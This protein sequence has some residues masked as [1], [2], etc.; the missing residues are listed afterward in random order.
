MSADG[1]AALLAAARAGDGDAFGRLAEPQRHGIRLHCYRFLGSLEDAEDLTQETLL[2]AWRRLDGFEGRSSF[3]HWLYRIATNACLDARDARSRRLLP[4]DLGSDPNPSG[5]PG[6]PPAEV[7]W[8]EPYPDSL[9][10]LVADPEPGPE[11][12]YD[13]RESV[14][15]AFVAALQHLPPR[16]RAALL[17]HDVLAW[18]AAETA[19]LLGSS[20]PGVNSALQRARATLSKRLPVRAETS[21]QDLCAA[22]RELLT[23]YVRAWE[24]GDLAALVS[25][26]KHDAL[27]TMPPVPEWYRGH[28]GIAGFLAAQWQA[29]GPFRLLPTGA[30][31]QPAFGLYGAGG[32]DGAPRPLTI[33]VLRIEAGLI[34][35]IVGF[36]EPSAFGYAGADLF[37]RFGLPPSVSR[38]D[39]AVGRLAR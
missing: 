2:R 4:N 11:A 18:S 31:G 22:D 12:R 16:Q 17:L 29:L 21:G 6:A 8:L 13:R 14:E 32:A 36:I 28:E 5:P 33:Q 26:L 34:A 19:S 23:R 39:P 7:E 24:G 38:P 30:N 35:E 37:P 1:D 3:R 9:L 10:E 25:L 27:L 15:L 20:V